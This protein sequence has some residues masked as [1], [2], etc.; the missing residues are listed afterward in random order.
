MVDWVQILFAQHLFRAAVEQARIGYLVGCARSRECVAVDV[1]WDVRGAAEVAR[2]AKMKMCEAAIVTSALPEATGGEAP[3]GLRLPSGTRVPGLSELVH[4]HGMEVRAHPS[5]LGPVLQRCGL[6]AWQGSSL[7][8]GEG[9]RVGC[10][11][12]KVLH[13][14]GCDLGAICLHASQHSEERSGG[15]RRSVALFSGNTLLPGSC[16]RLSDVEGMYASLRLLSELPDSTILYPSCGAFGETS[17]IGMEKATGLLKPMAPLRWLR[18]VGD[19]KSEETGDGDGVCGG[20]NGRS[21]EEVATRPGVAPRTRNAPWERDTAQGSVAKQ[22][23]A[24]VPLAAVRIDAGDGPAIR[25]AITRDGYAVVAAVA[26]E[27]ELERLRDLM[28]R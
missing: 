5:C 14:P 25:E 9:L 20:K 4:E 21:G 11:E 27:E 28:W 1:A 6:E 19:R 24:L 3:T 18:M 17:S 12:L 22:P 26:N 15:D 23:R 7:A 10:C 2:R 16:G 13:T 8:H